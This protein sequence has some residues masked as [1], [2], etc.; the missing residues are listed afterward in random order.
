MWRR[1]ALYERVASIEDVVSIMRQLESIWSEF[2]RSAG[3]GQADW[4]PAVSPTE[5]STPSP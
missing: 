2:D 5:L 4:E 1:R 3:A